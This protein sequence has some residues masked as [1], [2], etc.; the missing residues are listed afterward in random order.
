MHFTAA[1]IALSALATTSLAAP[2]PA[3]DIESRSNSAIVT[4][5][6][7]DTCNGNSEQF[8]VV[9]GGDRCVRV[10]NKRSI[11]ISGG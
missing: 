1:F 6:S 11:A 8:T 4:T 7:G 5:Y 10:S 9:G 3:L 2:S